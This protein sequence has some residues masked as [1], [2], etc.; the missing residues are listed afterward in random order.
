MMVIDNYS[1][2]IQS[3][4]VS[5]G[6]LSAKMKERSHLSPQCYNIQYEVRTHVTHLI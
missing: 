1:V 3:C 4:S 6:A 2:L 5:V